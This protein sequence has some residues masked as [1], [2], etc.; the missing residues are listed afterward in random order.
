[1]SAVQ[2]YSPTVPQQPR[3]T[4]AS[5]KSRGMQSR[6]P[7]RRGCPELFAQA[8]NKWDLIHEND[9]PKYREEILKRPSIAEYT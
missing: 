9:Q 6:P 5:A 4:K 8:I 1:M 2:T 3:K 7:L